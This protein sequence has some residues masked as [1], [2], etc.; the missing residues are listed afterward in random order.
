MEENLRWYKKKNLD[1]LSSVLLNKGYLIH[2]VFSVKDAEER[3]LSLLDKNKKVTLG[4]SWELMNEEF[5]FQLREYD[6]FDRFGDNSEEIKR[7]SLTS[8]ISIIEGE[9]VTEKG[10][11]ITVGD[12]NTSSALFGA[13]QLIVLIS[14][15]KIV[16]NINE[17]FDKVKANEKY[18]RLRAEKLGNI[19]DGLSIGVIENGNKFNKRISVVMT[20]ENTGL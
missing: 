1:R 17:A 6:F 18:Y 3:I 2:G 11:I 9:Y 7:A 8:N 19:S 10:Q 20:V 13:E 14:E 16:K 4:D 15:N 12:Y 5:I